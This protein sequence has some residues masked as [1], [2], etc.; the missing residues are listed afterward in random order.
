[1]FP[2]YRAALDREGAV[3][4][5]DQIYR[6]IEVLLTQPAARRTAQRACRLLLVDEFQDLTPAHLL[7]IRL[8]AAPGGAVFGVGDDD[9][10]IYGY[11]GADPAWLIDFATW[12]PGAEDHPLEVNYRCPAAW[13]RSPTGCCATIGDAS[14]RRSGPRRT[15]PGGWDAVSS[16]DPV[17][18]A[19]VGGPRRRSTPARPSAD[20]AV[21]TRVNATLVPVQVALT[22]AGVPISGGV[23]AEFLERT[24]VRSALAWLRLARGS[25]VRRDDIGEAL[26]RPS[27]GLQSTRSRDWAGEQ[28]D[29]AGLERLAARLTNDR[30]ATKITDFAVDLAR[31]TGLLRRKSTTSDVLDALIDQIGLGGAVATLDH[32]RQG[33]NRR[34]RAT[35][36]S[37]SVSSLGSTR[38][39]R[40]SSVGSAIS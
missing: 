6:A 27:R 31:L 30:D 7:L 26:R 4:F 25:G 16:D 2:Q 10:T 39:S 20:I 14:T 8:L 40:R 37:P 23:G 22:A 9:Q 18:A 1:M 15:L 13:S 5:D 29:V 19:V 11:N 21:L 35:I 34:R 12:F 32:S 24:A 38:T 17:A 36:C 28:R 33:M 3:D